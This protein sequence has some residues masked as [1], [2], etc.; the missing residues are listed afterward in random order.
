MKNY[1]N[2]VSKLATPSSFVAAGLGLFSLS[3]VFS[4]VSRIFFLC[5][6]L[7]FRTKLK[8][9][10]SYRDLFVATFSYLDGNANKKV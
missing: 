3:H 2:A 7:V 10:F 1:V 8:L 6:D 9:L 5:G 4:F